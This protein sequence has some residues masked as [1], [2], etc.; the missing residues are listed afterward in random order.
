M[1]PH[2]S[3]FDSL[4]FTALFQ[5]FVPFVVP[6]VPFVP[7]VQFVQFSTALL[8]RQYVFPEI[9]YFPKNV[10]DRGGLVSDGKSDRESDVDPNCMQ[11]GRRNGCKNVRLDGPLRI[12]SS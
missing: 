7:F 11:I 1:A 3:F 6:F 5:P 2:T 10:G 9:Y 8:P 4:S 12:L